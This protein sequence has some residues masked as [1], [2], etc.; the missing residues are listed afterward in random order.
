MEDDLIFW[1]MEDNLNFW[2]IEDDHNFFE[3]WEMTLNFKVYGT[4]RKFYNKRNASIG[5]YILANPS[6]S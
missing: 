1:E 4:S 2:K 5:K 3:K 6:F